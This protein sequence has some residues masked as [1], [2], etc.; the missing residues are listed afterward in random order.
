MLRYAESSGILPKSQFGFRAGRSTFNAIA[1]MHDMWLKNWRAGKSQ[2]IT[3]FD[4][5]SAFDTLSSDIFTSKLKI[6]GFDQKSRNFFKSYLSNRKQV[7]IV[8][9]S[10]SEL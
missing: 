9:A 7:V 8:G 3:C 2:T 6:Y 5:S 4:L 1:T 10:L